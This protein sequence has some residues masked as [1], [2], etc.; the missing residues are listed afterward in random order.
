MNNKRKKKKFAKWLNKLY[1]TKRENKRAALYEEEGSCTSHTQ[2]RKE[3]PHQKDNN[4]VSIYTLYDTIKVY[5]NLS[6]VYGYY[7]H[8]YINVEN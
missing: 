2:D 5:S 7:H 4:I 3:A 1:I 6:L 8:I